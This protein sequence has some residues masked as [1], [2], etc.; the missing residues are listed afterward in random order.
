MLL[1]YVDESGDTGLTSSP[2]SHY[3]LAAV[4]V[5]DS[6]WLDALDSVITFRRYLRQ[7]YGLSLTVELKAQNLVRGYRGQPA[8]TPARRAAIYSA[9]MQ[10]IAR[11][12]WPRV[13]AV[14]VNKSQ[15]RNRDQK[16][17]VFAHA[18][19][20]AIQRFQLWSDSQDT[21]LMIFH[22][23]G[24]DLLI[25]KQLRAM[26]RFHRVPS[27]YQPG[28][29][30]DATARRIIEDPSPRNSQGS[31]FV[32]LADLAAYAAVRAISPTPRM[33]GSQWALLGRTR[34]KEVSKHGS[35]PYGIVVWPR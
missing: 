23:E 12:D 16:L 9:A 14:V 27:Y 3:A 34:I 30:L 19:E 22:D 13:F 11:S 18:W 5:P 35:G 21:Q 28:Q 26:R 15:I 2:S 25:R 24:N 31:Y 4:L 20:F 33:D 17:V 6:R 10:F 8:L 32:Q 7:A 1:A 29:T